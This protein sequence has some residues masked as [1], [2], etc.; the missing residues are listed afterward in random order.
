MSRREWFLRSGGVLAA[1][2]VSRPARA[3]EETSGPTVRV[4][5]F[6]IRYGTAEDGDNRWERRCDLVVS[7]IQDFGPD[8]LGLQEVL[9]FQ[10]DYL[11]ERLPG[12]AFHG[13][14]RDDGK[15]AG[16]FAPVMFRRD[17]FE[18]LDSGHFWLSPTPS[19]PGSVG[20]DAALTRMM[21]WVLLRDRLRASGEVLILNTHFDHRGK[22]AR[23]ESARLIRRHCEDS[24]RDG[25]SVVLT[26][27]FNATEDDE[28]Y[29]L[30]LA[31][32]TGATPQL[33]D[34]YLE[35][36]AVRSADELTY[37]AWEGGTSGGR[38]DWILHSPDLKAI[39]AEINRR[40][41]AGRFPSDHYPVQVVLQYR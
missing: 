11:K 3:T 27:D 34:S 37:H 10:A 29:R 23:A 12:Y 15:Q 26:G 25:R 31:P 16:E 19:K 13:V 38:I 17:R 40:S 24:A 5:T 33:I 30:L 2:V 18:M 4:M 41:V 32:A 6:N 8:L 39:A 7:T 36:H 1:A 21:S 35:V 14:G 20:W 28:P 9:A 22:Q